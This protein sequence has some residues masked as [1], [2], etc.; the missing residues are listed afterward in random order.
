[1]KLIVFNVISYCY[2]NALTALFSVGHQPK[3]GLGRS[4]VEVSISHTI[5]HTPVSILLK[6]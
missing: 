2:I 1:M 6:E 5:K 3:S 4:V